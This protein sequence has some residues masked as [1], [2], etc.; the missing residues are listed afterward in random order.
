MKT[1]T[2]EVTHRFF[3]VKASCLDD[4]GKKV[5]GTGH[6]CLVLKPYGK[7]PENFKA[8]VSFKS[9]ADKLDR[10]LGVKIAEGRLLSGRPGRTFKVK[11]KNIDAAF[12]AA[13]ESMLTKNK[14]VV[15]KSQTVDRPFVPDWLHQAVVEQ[16]RKIHAL[17]R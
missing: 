9:P 11:A 7:N 17:K 3:S 13:L 16:E 2:V 6:V 5:N 15:R 12:Q 14:Q 1:D 10:D 8:A 4:D